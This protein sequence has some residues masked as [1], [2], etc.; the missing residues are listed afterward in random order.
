MG[1]QRSLHGLGALQA[2]VMEIVWSLGEATVA[3]VH[4]RINRRRRITYT[5]AL[6]AMQ[7]LAKRGWLV[8]RRD[9]RA[10]VYRAK[11]NRESAAAQ[12]LKNV[13]KQAFGG[14]P[15]LLLSNLIDQQEMS[16]EELADLRRLINARLKEQRR[17]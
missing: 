12:L 2:E 5:T 1:Q 16:E 8:Q 14:D 7:K 15:R 6:A 11:R 4:E 3:E 13:L 17:E 9:G 10:H